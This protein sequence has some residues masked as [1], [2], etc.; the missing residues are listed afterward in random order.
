MR[1]WMTGSVG[2]L[3]AVLAAGVTLSAP[4]GP[5]PA[6]AQDQP[7]GLHRRAPLRLQVGPAPSERLFRQC[8]DRPVI[9]HRATGDTVV[10]RTRCWWA[11]R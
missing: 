8:I 10:P 4:V 6:A 7:E 11:L 9:E 3:S 1:K 5:T 2:A